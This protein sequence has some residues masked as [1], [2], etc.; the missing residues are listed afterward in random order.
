MRKHLFI[1][2]G[3]GGSRPGKEEGAESR[4]RY[5]D[6]MTLPFENGSETSFRAEHL[7]GTKNSSR[8]SAA[9]G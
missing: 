5:L 6:H 4:T 1:Q 8:L 7:G 2:H 3:L 9:L